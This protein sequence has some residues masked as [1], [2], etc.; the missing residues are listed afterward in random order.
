MIPV[1]GKHSNSIKI[2][3]LPYEISPF[4]LFKKIYHRF[5]Y[6]YLLES[7]EGPEKLAEYSFI[8]F[9]PE[10]IVFSKNAEVTVTDLNRGEEVIYN[11]SD[12]LNI[13]RNLLNDYKTNYRNNRLVGGAVGYISYDMVRLWE[14]LPIVSIVC[15]IIIKKVPEYI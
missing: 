6:A 7:M 13:L 4:R 5:N 14:R 15:F 2:L 9:K 3:E 1:T 8:G 11:N 12:P 10:K